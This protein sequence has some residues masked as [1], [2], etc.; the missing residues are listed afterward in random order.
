MDLRF[1]VGDHPVHFAYGSSRKLKRNLFEDKPF[2]VDERWPTPRRQA[3]MVFGHTH[4]LWFD[5]R[6]VQFA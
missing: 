5:A 6:D 2:S 4:R 1:A 3:Q